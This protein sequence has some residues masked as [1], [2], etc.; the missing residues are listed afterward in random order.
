M[1]LAGC[2]KIGVVK[3]Q[4]KR[5][6]KKRSMRFLPDLFTVVAPTAACPITSA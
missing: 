2:K 6:G 5:S 1:T 4:D 3:K